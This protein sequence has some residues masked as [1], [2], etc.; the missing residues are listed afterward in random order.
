MKVLST[1]VQNLYCR[2]NTTPNAEFNVTDPLSKRDVSSLDY[3]QERTLDKDL[4]H[5][6]RYVR[7]NKHFLPKIVNSAYYLLNDPNNPPENARLSFKGYIDVEQ[8]DELAREQ[9]LPVSKVLGKRCWAYQHFDGSELLKIVCNPDGIRGVI[10]FPK[11]SKKD[12][13]RLEYQAHSLA[14]QLV[15]LLYE[16]QCFYPV[17]S[18]AAASGGMRMIPTLNLIGEM[19]LIPALQLRQEMEQA[20]RFRARAKMLKMPRSELIGYVGRVF[21]KD[22]N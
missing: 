7:I 18:L 21:S 11:T 12:A 14:L 10:F 15:D 5:E 22:K 6:S 1:L 4:P 3:F 20:S 16:Q 13:G 17:S 8:L 2:L 19:E 9:R